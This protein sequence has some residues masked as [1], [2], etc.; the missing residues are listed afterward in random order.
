[1]AHHPVAQE[2]NMIVTISRELV[3][4]RLSSIYSAEAKYWQ[5]KTMAMWKEL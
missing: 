1:M 5:L 4:K 3:A 2:P